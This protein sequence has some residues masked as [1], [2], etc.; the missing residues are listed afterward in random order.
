MMRKIFLVIIAFS[1]LSCQGNDLIKEF[2][3]TASLNL[4]ETKEMR[5]ILKKFKISVPKSWKTQLYYD[6]FKSQIYSAD[7]TKSLTETYVLDI[8]WHQGELNLNKF[9]EK[10]VID[11][12]AIKEQLTTYKSKFGKFNGK[13]AYWNLSEG[14][15][16]GYPY[17]HLELYIKSDY[18]EYFTITTKIYGQDN[19]D[20]RLC[21]SIKIVDKL[22]FIK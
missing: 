20:K 4:G 2:D 11:T 15:D 5:D 10:K 17:N 8:A 9:F 13:D 18:D 22:K 6:E 12:L 16:S 7:T 1:L 19:I 3:C 14:V 21:E